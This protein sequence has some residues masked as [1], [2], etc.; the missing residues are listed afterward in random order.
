MAII[1]TSK[2]FTLGSRYWGRS[3]IWQNYGFLIYGKTEIKC[4]YIPYREKL[5]ARHNVYYLVCSY[6]EERRMLDHH[7]SYC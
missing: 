1:A 6:L 4:Y 5:S 3:L 2:I 7:S